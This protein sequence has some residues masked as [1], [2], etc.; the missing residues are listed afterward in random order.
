MKQT[1][2]LKKKDFYH[3]MTVALQVYFSHF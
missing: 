1:V 3:M 2:Q